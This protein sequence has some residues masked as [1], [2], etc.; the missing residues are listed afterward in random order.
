MAKRSWCRL[1]DTGVVGKVG[2]VT[3]ASFIANT[4]IQTSVLD[5]WVVARA[6]RRVK[7]PTTVD[8]PT[9]AQENSERRADWGKWDRFCSQASAHRS[10]ASFASTT[11][12]RTI[13]SSVGVTLASRVVKLFRICARLRP[14]A[15]TT[16]SVEG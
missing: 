3:W 10:V 5:A 1:K 12:P 6:I 14:S 7:V 16:R 15:R 13:V 8:L 9:L 11:H 2:K 4:L